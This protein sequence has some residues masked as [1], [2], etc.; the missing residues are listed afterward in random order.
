MWKP[1]EPRIKVCQE[2]NLKQLQNELVQVRDELKEEDIL[3]GQRVQGCRMRSVSELA[4]ANLD[5]RHQI[6]QLL[7]TD[8]E[9]E[10]S[11]KKTATVADRAEASSLFAEFAIDFASQSMQYAL[12]A[13]MQ[14]LELQLRADH[15]S[16]PTGCPPS[17]TP[18]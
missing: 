2:K 17:G 7:Q 6:E 12:Y 5:F 15:L 3:L 13:A 1:A 18:V 11:G 4:Q 14:A 8:L 10:I 9:P 16:S